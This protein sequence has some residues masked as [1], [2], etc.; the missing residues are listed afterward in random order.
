MNPADLTAVELLTG[1]RSG[2]LSPV[3]ATR[4]ALGRIDAH[5]GTVNAFCLRD[6]D[7]ALA[8]AEEAAAIHRR[9]ATADPDVHEPDLAGS[10]SNL[11]QRYAAA[12]RYQAAVEASDEAVA[13]LRRLATADPAHE[14]SLTKALQAAALLRPAADSAPWPPA[15]S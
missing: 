12:G 1:Y 10:L 14:A 4:A 9:L 3:E 13:I 2:E 8:A 7:A 11:G 6:D 15:D 5:D